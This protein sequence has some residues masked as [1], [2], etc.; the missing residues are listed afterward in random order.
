MSSLPVYDKTGAEVGRYEIDPAVLQLPINKQL[1]HDAVVMYQTNQRQGTAKTKTRSEVEGSTK[2]LYRQK[3]TGNA[4]A[5]SRRSG[6]RRGGGH[7]FAKRP[8]DWVYRLPRKALQ[9]ATRMAIA[10]K[11]QGE[12]VTVIDALAFDKPT[13]KEMAKILKA[14][15]CDGQ[16]VLVATAEYD[17][18][19]LRSARNIPKVSVSPAGELNALNVLLPRRLLV[20]KAALDSLGSRLAETAKTTGGTAK[21]AGPK[22]RRAAAQQPAQE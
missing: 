15:K 7:I 20:T 17:Q 13:T 21:S 18:N 14:L 3:G 5:G 22:R 6:T 11:L 1:L 12:Q 16:S 2:K 8:R 19:V 4:R 10:S 9:L